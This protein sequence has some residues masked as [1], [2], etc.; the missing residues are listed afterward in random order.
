[1]IMADFDCLIMFGGIEAA[2]F[3]DQWTNRDLG[4][5]YNIKIRGAASDE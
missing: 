3:R 4:S 5:D 1:M 2:K